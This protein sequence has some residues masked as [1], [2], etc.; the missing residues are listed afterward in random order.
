MT[1]GPLLGLQAWRDLLNERAPDRPTDPY[2]IWADLTQYRAFARLGVDLG[3]SGFVQ[4]LTFAIELAPGASIVELNKH[5]MPSSG[6][7]YFRVTPTYS[8]PLPNAALARFVTAALS[9]R[10]ADSGEI[11]HRIETLL[12]APQVARVQ[13]GFSRGPTQDLPEQSGETDPILRENLPGPAVSP[14]VGS[15]KAVVAVIDDFIPFAHPQLRDRTGGTR[16]AALWDQSLFQLVPDKPWFGVPGFNYGRMMD[17]QRMNETMRSATRDGEVDESA[18]YHVPTVDPEAADPSLSGKARRFRRATSHGG[19]VL[20]LAAGNRPRRQD[21]GED[22]LLTNIRWEEDL[23]VP[24]VAVQLPVEQTTISSSRWLVVNALD[25]LRFV[26]RFARERFS[27]DTPQ[28]PV[29]LVVNLSYGGIAGA[30]NG[31]GM[32]ECAMDELMGAD[33]QMAVVL[34]AGNS[35]GAGVHAERNLGASQPA[36]FLVRVPPEKSFESYVEFW[37]PA[38]AAQMVLSVTSPLGQKQDVN[39]WS[40]K[41]ALEDSILTFE[42]SAHRVVAAAI[43]PPGGAPQ[44]KCRKMVLFALAATQLSHGRPHAQPGVWQIEFTYAQACA[45]EV[46]IEGWVERD[47]QVVAPRRPQWVRFA[48]EVA[49]LNDESTYES[50]IPGASDPARFY[51]GKVPRRGYITE[52]NTLTSIATGTLAFVAGAQVHRKGATTESCAVSRYTSEARDANSGPA[53]SAAADLGWATA[54]LCVDGN[55]SGATIRMNGTSIAAPQITRWLVQ[56]L[57]NG[58]TLDALRQ[59]VKQA[60]PASGNPSRAGRVSISLA[61][62]PSDLKAQPCG[63][64]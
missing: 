27:S 11:R 56:Q 22:D 15:P 42:D 50:D 45:V 47:D 35:Y 63:E 59:C 26:R 52:R 33:P 31:T 44:G 24:V 49:S 40:G 5:M 23:S 4:R 25:A 39:I 62:P 30:H 32:L 28:S 13:L 17:S 60:S 43:A 10:S 8:E 12:R 37:M 2:F 58:V 19:A 21:F 51:P 18:C 36:R 38:D 6:E 9:I 48:E 57:T 29:P 16:L 3:K 34:A 7:P 64:T 46:L 54:G 20:C 14:S 55:V 53:F 61:S 1:F 41:A